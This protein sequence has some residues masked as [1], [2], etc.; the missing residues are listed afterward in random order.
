MEIY[1]DAQWARMEPHCLV[2]VIDREGTVVK[3][4][5]YFFKLYCGSLEPAVL[6]VIPPLP[7]I[8]QM[9]YCF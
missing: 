6:G 2:K 3:I 8:R 1:T 9:E 4:I 7:R 5:G